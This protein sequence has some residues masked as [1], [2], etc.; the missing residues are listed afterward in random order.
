LDQGSPQKAL[1]IAVAI[2]S[3]DLN[4]GHFVI[5]LII[6]GVDPNST[7]ESDEIIIHSTS[8]DLEDNIQPTRI[9]LEVCNPYQINCFRKTTAGVNETPVT[10]IPSDLPGLGSVPAHLSDFIRVKRITHESSVVSVGLAIQSTG[11]S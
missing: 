7:V 8:L 10:V 11:M 1:G 6:L 9:V 5:G 3:I 2:A 4:N